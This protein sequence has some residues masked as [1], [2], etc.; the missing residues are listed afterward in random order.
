M[1]NKRIPDDVL[2]LSDREAV[3]DI[4]SNQDEYDQMI[5]QI[6]GT[7]PGTPVQG[8]VAPDPAEEQNAGGEP[9]APSASADLTPEEIAVF[10]K[11]GLCDEHGVFYKSYKTPK[12]F[13]EGVQ[14][15]DRLISKRLE[16]HPEELAAYLQEHPELIPKP[17][18]AP[19]S[20]TPTATPAPEQARSTETPRLEM[21]GQQQPV[22]TAADRQRIAEEWVEQYVPQ[23]G[24]V[25]QQRYAP[26]LRAYEVEYP[27]TVEGWTEL[28]EHYPGIYAE[29]LRDQT[30]LQYERQRIIDMGVRQLEA[31]DQRVAGRA[32][33]EQQIL[34]K[35][36]AYL[37]DVWGLEDPQ[38]ISELR[39]ELE[40]LRGNPAAGI[41][42]DP[43]YFADA[44]GMNVPYLREDALRNFALAT[45]G[46]VL[47]DTA[48]QRAS[49]SE[50]APP[51]PPEKTTEQKAREAADER[52]A[53]AG[54]FPTSA[55][56][57]VSTTSKSQ[58]GASHPMPSPAE[59]RDPF[60]R[61]KN[62]R[63]PKIAQQI[64]AWIDGLAPEK[65][66]EYYRQR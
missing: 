64:Y 37:K 65:K 11:H 40:I 45:R 42:P 30:T 4:L 21:P 14:N 52:R 28:R 44:D 25:L 58:P 13:L 22:M 6:H 50:P 49:K 56:G 54:T 17:E 32:P 62:L 12:A 7:D 10:H 61:D 1:D 34:D 63:D 55:A 48:V 20:T 8:P 18:E 46:G 51:A 19:A 60:W 57:T 15:K 5:E 24:D 33:A 43:R 38:V 59:Y 23:I 66:A 27:T 35:D 16:D 31:Y 2:Y 47:R 26:Q 36:L 53:Q 29:I 39:A 9:A 41:A 3:R